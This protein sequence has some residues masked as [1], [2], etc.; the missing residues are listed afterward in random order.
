MQPSGNNLVLKKTIEQCG[1]PILLFLLNHLNLHLRFLLSLI[2]ELILR[3]K[4]NYIVWQTFIVTKYDWNLGEEIND[5]NKNYNDISNFNNTEINNNKNNNDNSTFNNTEI[6][7]NN[8]IIY[9][10]DDDS[11]GLGE[12]MDP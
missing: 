12:I 5:N 8:T 1:L 9:N 2:G 6:N 4:Y 11:I 7:T 3:D 10:N